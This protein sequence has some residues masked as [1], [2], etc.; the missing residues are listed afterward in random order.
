M[1]KESPSPI[2][3]AELDRVLGSWFSDMYA[4]LLTACADTKEYVLLS[5]SQLVSLV[6]SRYPNRTLWVVYVATV[7]IVALITMKPN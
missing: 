1:Q 5:A 6:C 7:V 2:H 3:G 4:L